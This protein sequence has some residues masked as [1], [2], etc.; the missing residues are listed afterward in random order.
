M[1]NYVYGKNACIEV[2]N[3]R[4]CIKGYILKGNSLENL[5]KKNH[6]NYSVVDKKTL[7]RLTNNANHQ[8]IV[9]ECK[10]Y[11]LYKLNEIIKED[12]GF[13]VMLDGIQDPHNFGAIIRTCE[14]AGI[15]GIIYKK[16]NSVKLNDTV[17]KVACGALEYQKI[18]E[19]TNLTNTIKELKE[20]GYW[21]IG[22]SDKATQDY[23][24][25][26][27]KGNIV[28]IIGNEGVGVSRLVKDN[29]DFLI[30]L[31][32]NGHVNSLNASVATGIFIYHINNQRNK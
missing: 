19:V 8:G 27:Y 25:L 31:P 1:S 28:L 26:D 5:L 18:C 13:I 7:D 14:A 22:T 30:S 32:I 2:I 3:N 4:R 23:S 12:N 17:A 10:D 16:N 15:D 9:L 20:K 29:C 6:I 21:I 24:K 11:K